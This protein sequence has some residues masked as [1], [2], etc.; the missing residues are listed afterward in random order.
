MK[1]ISG[2]YD[3]IISLENLQAADIIASIGKK[4]QSGVIRHNKVRE[5]NILS[6]HAKLKEKAFKTSEYTTFMVY[7][8]K[9]RQVYRLPYYPDRIVHHAIMLVLEPIWV[10]CLTA[11]TYSCIKGRGIH[12]ASFALRNALKDREGTKYC[13]KLDIKKFYP[14][15]DHGVLKSIIRKK[16]KDHDL[17]DLLDEIIDSAPGLPIGNLMSQ[18]FANL[19]LNCFDHFLKEV[20]RVKYYFRYCDDLVILSDN[21][22]YLH[23][24]LADIREYLSV[25]LKLTI[26][27]NYQIFPVEA[28]GIDFVGYPTWHDYVRL[29][30]S[31]K[32]RLCKKLSRKPNLKSFAAYYGWL[33]HCNSR[34]L[35]KKLINEK[36][37]GF[38]DQ[39]YLQ[40]F[41][42]QKH[43]NG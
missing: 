28:R 7:E 34:H 26:K 11:D 38:G 6:L 21:K 29:R 14:S 25:K 1:R 19:Y 30:K 13:L 42:R 22:P 27:S 10:D 20:K 23:Q 40:E 32:K 24:L 43:P 9:E 17:L 41:R 18:Y 2:L 36:V 31:I 3:R 4:K 33:K 16:I 15:V 35:L 37:T 8:P 12:A 39:T 5:A